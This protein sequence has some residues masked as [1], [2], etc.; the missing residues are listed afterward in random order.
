MYSIYDEQ[1]N[2]KLHVLL[3]Q[4]EQFLCCPSFLCMCILVL[5]LS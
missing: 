3:V 2:V 5:F 4:K 1:D